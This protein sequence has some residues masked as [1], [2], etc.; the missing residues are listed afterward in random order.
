[1][2]ET[3]SPNP[4]QEKRNP[5]PV[6][7][8]L[9][10]A[11]IAGLSAYI[12]YDYFQGASEKVKMEERIEADSLKISD[13]DARYMA[14]MDTLLSYRGLNRE[15]DSIIKS[16]E[17]ELSNCRSTF[18]SSVQR[19]KINDADYK[20]QIEELNGMV[21]SLKMQ[22]AQLQADNKLMLFQRDSL[23]RIVLV[24]ADSITY[25]ADSNAHLEKR[26]TIGSLLK[27]TVI[28]AAGIKTKGN[29]KEKATKKDSKTTQLRVCFTVPANNVALAEKKI[30]YIRFI[31]P[32]GKT[33]AARDSARVISK[34]ET[35]ELIPYSTTAKIN[36]KNEVAST[37]GYFQGTDSFA[38]GTY[39]TE[40]YQD[41]YLIGSTRFD[42]K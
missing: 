5:I 6:I 32:D 26:I 36:Y 4:Q 3:A 9:A 40:I 25:L 18:L 31:S 17:N 35:G 28:E 16:M 33:L 24:Q 30:F 2:S 38:E 14:V 13:L 21:A 29:G 1:M 39:T 23:G 10:L 42:L 41:G 12:I 11:V 19:N 22:I 20:K 34:A 15:L 27:P 7:F 37:C 8:Y